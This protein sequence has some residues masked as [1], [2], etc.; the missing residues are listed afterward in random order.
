MLD[1]FRYA[2]TTELES[3]GNRSEGKAGAGGDGVVRVLL[4]S[5][6]GLTRFQNWAPR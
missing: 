4:E 6:G 3:D 5:T 2:R 1:T